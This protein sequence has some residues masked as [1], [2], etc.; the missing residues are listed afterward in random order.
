MKGF[1]T[2]ELLDSGD[3]TS[4]VGAGFAGFAVGPLGCRSVSSISLAFA[5]RVVERGNL[6]LGCLGGGGSPIRPSSESPEETVRGDRVDEGISETEANCALV[7][8]SCSSS[9][10]RL[11]EMIS[12]FLTISRLLVLPSIG[13]TSGD[14]QE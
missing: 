11:G 7:L 4:I 8:S 14:S 10:S 13:M 3:S 1:D 9:A 12:R 5:A 2:E 6:T